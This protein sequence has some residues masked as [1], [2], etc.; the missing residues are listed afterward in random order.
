MEAQEEA[1]KFAVKVP[2][3]VILSVASGLSGLEP[4][5]AAI[6]SQVEAVRESCI[7]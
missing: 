1:L 5:I 7:G 4:K 6:E 3:F 2:N